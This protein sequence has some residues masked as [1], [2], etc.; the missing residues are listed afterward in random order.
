[1]QESVFQTILKAF[2]PKTQKHQYQTATAAT[3]IL[4]AQ[5]AI[6]P[7]TTATVS[8]ATSVRT[9]DITNAHSAP[10]EATKQNT[11]AYPIT[12]VPAHHRAQP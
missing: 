7:T 3:A 8:L 5:A 6:P 4:T 12:A 2:L 11:S 9:R 10:A 1:M